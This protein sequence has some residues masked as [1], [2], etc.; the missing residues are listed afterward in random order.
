MY[1]DEL[2]QKHRMN[3]PHSTEFDTLKVNNYIVRSYNN[4]SNQHCNKENQ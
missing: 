1:K 3:D 4:C 2:Y